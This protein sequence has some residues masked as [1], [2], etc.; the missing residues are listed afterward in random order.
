MVKHPLPLMGNGAERY[1]YVHPDDSSLVVKILKDKKEEDNR[2][3]IFQ[4]A[5]NIEWF[6]WETFPDLRKWLVPCVDMTLDGKQLIM[7]R[8]RSITPVQRKSI[9]VPSCFVDHKTKNCIQIDGKILVCD[10]G[11][12]GVLKKLGVKYETN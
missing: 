10:Y 3:S 7:K 9:K 12:V 6:I 1:V 4:N 5:N 11:C 2:L 8:G